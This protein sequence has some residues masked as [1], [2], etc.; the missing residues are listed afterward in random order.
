MSDYV[1]PY[2]RLRLFLDHI[3]MEEAES[4][5]LDR[6]APL[7]TARKDEFAEYF[8]R[9]FL[10]I[11][12]TRHFLDPEETPGRMIRVWAAWL[13]KF[14]QSKTDDEFLAY[15]WGVGV[16]HVEVGLDQ[17]FSNLGF[18]MIRQF[19]HGVVISH[20][21]ADLRDV[22]LSSVNKKLDLCLLVETA[23]YIE[24]T[25]SCDI[26]VMAEV[27]DRV[28]NPA[29]VIGWNIKKLQRN[30]EKGTREYGVYQMLMSEN[31]RLETMVRDIRVY[32]DIF[33][34][35][36]MAEIISLDSVITAAL[37]R[38]RISETFPSVRVDLDLPQNALLMRGDRKWIEHFFYYLLENGAE[39]ANQD[40][41]FVRVSSGIDPSVPIDVRID[42]VNSGVAPDGEVERLFTPFFSTKVE[43]TGFG[44][45]IARLIARKHHGTLSI[46]AEGAGGTRVTAML[47]GA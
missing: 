14:F 22:A 33:Q 19:C 41:G 9:I 3:G 38:L 42:I 32:M 35:E 44:L 2:P 43:G 39:A 15:Q 24:N 16:R 1:S 36:P 12:E 21:P 20:V 4:D 11:A 10:D 46:R 31:Q 25:I 45:P 28:R 7:F 26:E 34:G 13:A 6:I 17:R 18:A 37:E 29:M 27:A 40:D 8:H 5:V 30:V 23:A 47:P